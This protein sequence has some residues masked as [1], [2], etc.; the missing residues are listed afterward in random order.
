MARIVFP[1]AAAR[2]PFPPECIPIQHNYRCPARKCRIHVLVLG[3]HT[4]LPRSART[5]RPAAVRQRAP[6]LPAGEIHSSAGAANVRQAPA[7]NWS[8]PLTIKPPRPQAACAE[9][10]PEKPAIQARRSPANRAIT[11]P[12]KQVPG[13]ITGV[14]PNLV[15]VSA[16]PDGPRPGGLTWPG[17]RIV[18]AQQP[19]PGA[20]LRRW[21]NLVIEFEE[22]RGG[23]GAGD[24]EPRSP[25]PDPGALAA[26]LP[27]PVEPGNP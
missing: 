15:V 24:R 17:T 10:N 12:T 7:R 8:R 16:E 1:V 20:R 27:P 19:A 3:G 22:R 6:P 25:L 4:W 14:S 18:T 2:R 21:D 13:S 5:G 26:E 11:E 23:E 9:T